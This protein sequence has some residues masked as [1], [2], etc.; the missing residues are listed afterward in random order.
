[1]VQACRDPRELDKTVAQ[2]AGDESRQSSNDPAHRGWDKFIR[3]PISSAVELQ[4]DQEL[5]H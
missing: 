4:G 1:M 3:S 2:R 5:E